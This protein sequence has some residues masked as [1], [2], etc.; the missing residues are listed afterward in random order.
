VTAADA[1]LPLVV[2]HDEAGEFYIEQ[3][4]GRVARMTYTRTDPRAITIDHTEV[5]DVLRGKGAGKLLVT[6]AVEWARAEGITITPVCRFARATFDKD[7]SLADVL[8]PRAT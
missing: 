4:G 5:G 7:P 1:G 6:A 8:A 3:D 2:H